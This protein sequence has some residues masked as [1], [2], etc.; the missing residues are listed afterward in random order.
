MLILRFTSIALGNIADIAT[1]IARS[2]GSRSLGQGFSNRLRHRCAELASL[3]GTQGWDRSELVPGLRSIAFK[4]YV[5]FFR[6][7]HKSLEVVAVLE[8]HRDINAYFED[9][10]L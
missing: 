3:P 4:R 9:R 10:Q 7:D 6:Y 1:Y 8:G 2:S 5:I